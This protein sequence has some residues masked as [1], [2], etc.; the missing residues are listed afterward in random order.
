MD[1]LLIYCLCKLVK[2]AK[3]QHDKL[4]LLEKNLRKTEGLLVEE[5]EKNQKLINKRDAFSKIN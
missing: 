2:I 1:I 5:M 4:E 3:S